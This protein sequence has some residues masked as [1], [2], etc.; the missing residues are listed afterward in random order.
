MVC[1]RYICH[2]LSYEPLGL[3]INV[4]IP[5]GTRPGAKLPVAAVSAKYDGFWIV[6]TYLLTYL[7]VDIRR[8]VA[9]TSEDPTST[10][11]GL[12]RWLPSRVECGVRTLPGL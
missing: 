1:L 3:N 10:A 11:D 7:L 4:I 12:T 2:C 8:F 6:L 5:A 9:A